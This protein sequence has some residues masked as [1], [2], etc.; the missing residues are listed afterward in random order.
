MRSR[1]EITWPRHY[2]LDEFPLF[3]KFF[4]DLAG[5]WDL[6]DFWPFDF[7]DFLAI[8]TP[9]SPSLSSSS[10]TSSLSKV[11]FSNSAAVFSIEVG[12]VVIL[13]KLWINCQ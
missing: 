3:D 2:K 10:L 5:F 7:P 12:K 11:D 9:P 13:L 6:D 4:L 1:D 8:S